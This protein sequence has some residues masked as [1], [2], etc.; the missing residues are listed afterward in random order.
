MDPAQLDKVLHNGTGFDLKLILDREG[1]MLTSL[2]TDPPRSVFMLVGPEGGFD[3]T[4]KEAAQGSGFRPV[5][6]SGAVLRTETAA[7]AGL[8]LITARWER[9]GD[10]APNGSGKE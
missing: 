2:N 3:P 1:P 7:L 5:R 8:A 9:P 6:L 4:E 10:A